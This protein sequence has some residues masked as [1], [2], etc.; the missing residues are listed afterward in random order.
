M[1]K[2]L[3]F[4]TTAGGSYLKAFLT[5]AALY[6]YNH[7]GITGLDWKD[8]ATAIG[9]SFIPSIWKSYIPEGGFWNTAIGNYLKMLIPLVIAFFIDHGSIFGVD[10]SQFWN[11][12]VM[13]VIPMLINTGNTQDPR[14]GFKEKSLK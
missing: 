11:Y 12:I 1:K 9:L 5:F 14:Y 7:G 8:F 13:A 10:W 3:L 4:L 2:F 6:L